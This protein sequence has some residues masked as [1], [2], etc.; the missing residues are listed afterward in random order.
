MSMPNYPTISPEITREK[1]LN[2]IIASI[3]MEELGLSHIINAEGEKLQY[4]L[5]TLPNQYG[6]CASVKDVLDVNKSIT[7]LLETVMENQILLKN[8]LEKVLNAQQV[9]DNQKCCSTQNYHCENTKSHTNTSCEEENVRCSNMCSNNQICKSTAMFKC[10]MKKCFIWNKN[11]CMLWTKCY[12]QGNDISLNYQN[13]GEIILAPNSKYLFNFL[14]NID[15]LRT[16]LGHIMVGIQMISEG[17]V[18]D[19]YNFH[20]SRC[21]CIK[22]KLSIS[23][24]G[25]I[26]TDKICNEP[27]SIIITLKEPDYAYVETADLSIIQI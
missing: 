25:T 27:F 26:I 17:A 6:S 21:K 24:S 19:L 16:C 22:Q 23:G 3:A 12:S 5:G 9:E 2:M 8:K 1:A 4:V 18:R 11:E 10:G 14:I 7:E 15:S 13:N 20:L